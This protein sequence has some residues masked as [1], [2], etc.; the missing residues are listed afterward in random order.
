MPSWKDFNG[1]NLIEDGYKKD[2]ATTLVNNELGGRSNG[3]EI[4]HATKG[5]SGWSFGG[6]QLDLAKNSNAR[7]LMKDILNHQYG[8]GYYES[9]E[10]LLKGDNHS[11]DSVSAT[12]DKTKINN[13]LSS[14]YGRKA[15]DQD[16]VSAIDKIVSH[17]DSVESRLGITLSAGE[18]LMLADYHNQYTLSLDNTT[19]NSMLKKLQDRVDQNGDLSID[20]IKEFAQ[21]TKYY[22]ENEKVQGQRINNTYKAAQEL[23]SLENSD[24]NQTN[25]ENNLDNLPSTSAGNENTDDTTTPTNNTNI[26]DTNYTITNTYEGGYGTITER[27]YADGSISYDVPNQNGGIDVVTIDKDGNLIRNDFDTSSDYQT[28]A[29]FMNELLK[30]FDNSNDEGVNLDDGVLVADSGQIAT[31]GCNGYIDDDTTTEEPTNNQET[32]YSALGNAAV[33]QIGSLIMAN[34]SFSDIESV[35]VTTSI[36]T[37]ADYAT[38]NTAKNGEFD[39]QDSALDNLK[40]AVLSFAIS[41]YFANNDNISDILGMNDTFAGDML[42]YTATFGIGYM[43]NAYYASQ[44]AVTATEIKDA[45]ALLNGANLAN[46]FSGAVGGYLGSVVANELMGWDTESEMIGSSIGSA[47]GAIAVVLMTNPV[48]WVAMGL[49]AFGGSFIGSFVGGIVGGLFGGSEP[50]PPTAYAEYGFDEETLSYLVEASGSS[51]G[52]NEEAMKNIAESLAN[53]FINMITIPGGQLVDASAMPDILV[54]QRDN[55]LTINGARG[56]FDTIN[57]TM[58]DAISPEMPFMNVEGGDKYIL[59]AMNRTNEKFLEGDPDAQGRVDLD[60]LYTNIALAKDYSNYMNKVM[61]VL[62]AKQI[63]NNFLKVA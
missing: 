28:D 36:A 42:D 6:H 26:P 8:K 58:A 30:K 31:D 10:S 17:I 34:N 59:R 20:D 61:I 32:D 24:N 15:I 5:E 51:D 29:E 47:L 9:V 49:M 62:D 53:H 23:D 46:A 13:A 22:K 55:D 44:M 11:F 43:A 3:Y 56:S 25:N 12:K 48:G 52:G 54:T 1:L 41:S 27:I 4:S 21:D 33:I 50:P 19:K 14:D 37:I 7:T 57:Q 40:G 16:F 2:V 38:Y 45:S 18:K 35:A 60:E 39:V 63:N